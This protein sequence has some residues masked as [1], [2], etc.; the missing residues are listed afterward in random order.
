MHKVQVG[1]VLDRT[2]FLHLAGRSITIEDI[3]AADPVTYAS[4]K[5]ILEMRAS[6]IDDLSLT[7]SRDVHTLGSNIFRG[8]SYLRV[9]KDN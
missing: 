8:C 6:D 9:S 5:R 3:D 4:C 7:F 1:I 2:L